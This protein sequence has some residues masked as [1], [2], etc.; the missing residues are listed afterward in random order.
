MPVATKIVEYIER[1]SWIRAMFEAGAKLKAEHGEENVFDFSLGN[2]NLDPP[3]DFYHVARRLLGEPQ[4]GDH[5]YGP[6][7]G[8]V[9]V[10]QKVA[11]YLSKIHEV[12]LTADS[13]IMT[14]GAAGGLNIALKTILNPDDEVVVPAPLFVEYNFYIEN[15]GGKMVI[16][17]TKED[18]SLDVDA[19]AEAINPKTAAVLIN[20]PNN[21]TGA[22]YSQEQINDLA[23]MLTAKSNE[24]G[25]Q[26]YL[27][28][29][30]PYRQ[31]VFDGLHVPSTLKAYPN[32][33]VATS[34]SK[35]LS[36]PGERI[37]YV[38]V[39][40]GAADH[41]LLMGGMTLAN[42]I[43]GFVNAPVLQQRIVAELLEHSADISQYAR[44]R[45]L[46]CKVLDDA[47]YDFIKPGGTFYVYP[48]SP[49]ADDVAFVRAAQE[50]N[51][52]LVPGTGFAGP[53]HFRIAF[54][55]SD[56][57]IER[58]AGAFKKVR[59]RF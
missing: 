39:G 7:S 38:A 42:R 52:L 24:I 26:I 17:P 51:L 45:E 18:F 30:E 46:I 14:V 11:E 31:I 36:L 54:C 28:S 16:V 57:T 34:F 1:A 56:E 27:I 58:S 20:N 3:E 55:C 12:P 4:P 53:G 23:S 8:H 59:N 15:H 10:R 41:D 29:D 48:K 5:S 43:L 22:V 44:K 25:R 33:I 13:I 40:K 9:P 6:N 37:G 2:P 21:P 35:N 32:S 19:L 47:G 49:I 50:E